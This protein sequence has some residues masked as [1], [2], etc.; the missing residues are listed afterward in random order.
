[1]TLT[2]LSPLYTPAHLLGAKFA[3]MGGWKLAETFSGVESDAAAARQSVALADTSAHGKV[4][5]EGV[6]AIEVM[7]A[8]LGVAPDNPGAGVI[9]EGGYVYRLRP[10]QFFVVTPPGGEAEMLTRLEK[11]VADR[12]AFV[13]VTDLSQGLAEMRLIGPNSRSVLSKV[14]GLDFSAE[15]F[16]NLTAKQ[17]SLAKTKQLLIRRD[18][19]SLPA[20]T[21]SGAQSLSAYVW[22]V[23]LE[24]GQEFGIAPIGVAAMRVLEMA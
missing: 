7:K 5:V 10:D 16:P 9:V 22:E 13:T 3:E 20:F 14:C 17:T 18:F 2:K 12:S 24:A 11:A 6:A 23:V 4:Q 21:F 19:G 8:A 1:M 15:A